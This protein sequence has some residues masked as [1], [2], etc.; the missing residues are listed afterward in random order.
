ML[1]LLIG[2]CLGYLGYRIIKKVAGSLGLWPQ[3]PRPLDDREPDVQDLH[4][5]ARSPQDRPGRQNVFFL[6]RRLSE[7]LHE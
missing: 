4:S 3:A 7:A 6:L 1:R 5:P 2:L